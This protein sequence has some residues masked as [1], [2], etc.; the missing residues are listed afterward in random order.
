M[1][2]RLVNEEITSDKVPISK[3]ELFH[4]M[5]NRQIIESKLPPFEEI[6]G[7]GQARGQRGQLPTRSHDSDDSVSRPA[8]GT[9][10]GGIDMLKTA[11]ETVSHKQEKDTYFLKTPL[12]TCSSSPECADSSL[13]L[14]TVQWC[15]VAQPSLKCPS[16]ARRL[17]PWSRPSGGFSGSRPVSRPTLWPPAAPTWSGDRA[18]D[19]C[20]VDMLL[21]ST[22]E[23][24][25]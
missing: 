1:E 16:G 4:V 6:F 2:L 21:P 24:S 19:H 22:R 5:Y 9:W 15:S 14:S 23:R 10:S 18:Q 13:K 11:L 7:Q 20:T 3:K 17:T 8:S 25:A 12:D